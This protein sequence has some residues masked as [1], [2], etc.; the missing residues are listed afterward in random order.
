[1]RGRVQGKGTGLIIISCDMLVYKT[2]SIHYA[3]KTS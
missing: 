3:T 2:W 1:L